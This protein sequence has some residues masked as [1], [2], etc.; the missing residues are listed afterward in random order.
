MK[1]TIPTSIQDVTV[2]DYI[3]FHEAVKDIKDEKVIERK[4]LSILCNISDEEIDSIPVKEMIEIR[5]LL[6][7]V[8]S[9]Q[10][11]L[12]NIFEFN[13]IKYGLIPDWDDI[14]FGEF[15]DLSSFSDGVLD[16]DKIMAIMY[17]PIIKFRKRNNEYEIIKYNGLEDRVEI[18]NE[19]SASVGLSLIFFCKS[20]Y[21]KLMNHMDTYSPQV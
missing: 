15:L 16:M 21:N 3:K 10:P 4:A 20:V 7:S 17:R 5:N 8:L 6:I 1:I 2:R 14:T 13:G 9:E 19:V 11:D 12:V 18:M